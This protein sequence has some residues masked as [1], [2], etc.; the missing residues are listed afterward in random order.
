VE[1]RTDRNANAHLTIGKASFGEDALLAN[2]AAVIDEINRAKP[3]AAK[4]RYI[5]SITLTTAMGPGIRVD[6][7]KIREGEILASG[8]GNGA[9]PAG[10]PAAEAEETHPDEPSADDGP[11]PEQ[12]AAP[13]KDVAEESPQPDEADQEASSDG[14]EQPDEGSGEEG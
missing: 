9:A 5:H 1:Y 4:G 8:S 3:P 14:D 7:G 10:A 6:S 13:E 12:E 11:A 2:Y